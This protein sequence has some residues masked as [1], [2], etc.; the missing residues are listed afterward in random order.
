MQ[1]KATS[2]RHQ[3]QC[4][5]PAMR[6]LEV[7]RMHGGKTPRGPAS[8]HFKDGRYS[9]FLPSRLFAQYCAAANDPRLLELRESIATVDARIVDLL[10]R[11]DSGEAGSLWR[12]TQTAMGRIQRAQARGHGDA[13]EGAVG[14]LQRLITQGVA[15]YAAWHEVGELIEQ[16]RRLCESEQKRVT[17]A[18]EVLTVEQA[19]MLVGQVVDVIRTHVPDR[20]VLSAIALDLQALGYRKGHGQAPPDEVARRP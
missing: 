17:M 11:V 15:D 9:R 18:H 19:M 6:G 4:R 1:C 16:R 2:K 14:T 3:R 12:Q 8:P 5:N 13:L 10:Q 20:Q 7:C